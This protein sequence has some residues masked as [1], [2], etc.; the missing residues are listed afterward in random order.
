MEGILWMCAKMANLRSHIGNLEPIHQGEDPSIE[1]SQCFRSTGNPY[2]ARIFPE[3]DIAA[4]MQP[5]FDAPM[6]LVQGEQAR[7]VGFF[8]G[9]VAHPIDRL[10]TR[11]FSV[12]HVSV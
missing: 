5:I 10:L 12:L 1:G 9:E 7:G 6:C 2:L 3:G 8:P 4:I 11:F